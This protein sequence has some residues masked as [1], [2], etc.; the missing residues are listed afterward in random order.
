[1]NA[2]QRV[3]IAIQKKGR[4]NEPS[5]RFLASFGLKFLCG[6]EKELVTECTNKPVSIFNVRDN[7]IPNFVSR[8]D[9]DWGIVGL[10]VVR[11][12]K[13]QVN[14]SKRLGFCKCALVIAVPADSGITAVQRL[15]GKRIATSYPNVLRAFLKKKGITAKIVVVEGSVELA[16]Y[17]KAADAV[18]DITQ[19]GKTLR[20]FNLVPIQTVLKSEAVLIESP[21]KSRT[22]TGFLKLCVR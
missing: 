3:K 10:D 2:E 15:Q 13:A 8:G 4:L 22:K 7:D 6:S 19:T 16:P 17:L 9:V 11:E 20:E 21:N 1:M 14:V 12:S 5:R 18:C